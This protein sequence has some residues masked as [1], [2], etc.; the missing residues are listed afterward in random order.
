MYRTL[1]IFQLRF[2]LLGINVGHDV[3][4]WKQMF[5]CESR[6][7]SELSHF[8]EIRT[9]CLLLSSIMFKVRRE[10]L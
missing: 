10:V 8:V 3:M 9:V 5:Y 7:Q 4:Y 1:H 6:S 2:V